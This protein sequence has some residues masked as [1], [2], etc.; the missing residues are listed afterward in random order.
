MS[1]RPTGIQL[2][3][4]NTGNLFS[5]A[6]DTVD[7]QSTG[8]VGTNLTLRALRDIMMYA[9]EL[10]AFITGNSHLQFDADLALVSTTGM[11]IEDG[12]GISLNAPA[13]AFFGVTP[14]TAQP[15]VTG[16]KGANAALGSLL[17]ALA[18][19][20]LIVDSSGT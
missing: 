16:L 14:G 3:Q 6:A 19:L 8:G 11:L 2:E 15:T 20:G 13:L 18:S 17:T 10:N 9:A 7:I 5:V 12:L 1:C 4:V